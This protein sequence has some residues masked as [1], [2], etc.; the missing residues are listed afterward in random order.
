MKYL[1]LRSRNKV[2]QFYNYKYQSKIF[3]NVKQRKTIFKEHYFKHVTSSFVSLTE[4]HLS[5][6]QLKTDTKYLIVIN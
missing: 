3:Y 1:Q 4:E 5:G 6:H 2:L